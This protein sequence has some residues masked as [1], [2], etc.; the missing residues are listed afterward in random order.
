[1]RLENETSELELIAKAFRAISKEIS[2]EG[3]A[4]ALLK[5]ALGHS[6][7]DRGAVLLREGGEL[8]PKADAS[9]PRERAKVFASQ[10]PA[11]DFRLPADRSE[12]GLTR[13]ETVDSV[14]SGQSPSRV[15]P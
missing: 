12:R 9:F 14:D 11:G 5:A 2:Y 7:A 1:M 10:P 8:L 15:S 3:L 13:Q 4:K 6:G